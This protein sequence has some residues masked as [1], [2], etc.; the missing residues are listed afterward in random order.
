VCGTNAITISVVV[1]IGTVLHRACFPNPFPNVG[2]RFL[3][4]FPIWPQALSKPGRVKGNKTKLI[5]LF[6]FDLHRYNF[7][8]SF[9]HSS[10]ALQPILGPWPL[11]QFHNL[12]YTVG[13]TSWTS[14]QPVARPLPTHRTTQTQTHTQTSMP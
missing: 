2:T 8:H 11:L 1:N 10:V 14:Y 12:F 7:I 13:R 3:L 6:L 5:S 4:S 9:I